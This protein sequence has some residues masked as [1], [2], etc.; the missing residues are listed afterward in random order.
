MENQKPEESISEDAPEVSSLEGEELTEGELEQISG[1]GL[2]PPQSKKVSH[3]DVND[4]SKFNKGGFSSL[5]PQ[6]IPP[7]K[8]GFGK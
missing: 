4:V 2:V 7:G 5:N 8:F 3:K 6:P 1:G